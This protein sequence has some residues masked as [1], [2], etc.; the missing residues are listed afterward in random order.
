MDGSADTWAG[1]YGPCSLQLL[2]LGPPFYFRT[3]KLQIIIRQ[4]E[5][6]VNTDVLFTC[7][8][9]RVDDGSIIVVGVVKLCIQGYSAVCSGIGHLTL[10]LFPKERLQTL[11][12]VYVGDGGIEVNFLCFCYLWLLV[13]GIAHGSI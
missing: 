6:P 8:E 5:E 7:N 9:I 3:T 1:E 13:H 2:L 10:R 11:H 12:I 4:S